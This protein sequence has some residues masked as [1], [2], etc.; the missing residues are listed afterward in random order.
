MEQAKAGG[1]NFTVA[2]TVVVGVEGVTGALL[3]MGNKLFLRIFMTE[4][5]S[6]QLMS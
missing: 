2:F 6:G 5:T 4:V 1:Q 3:R